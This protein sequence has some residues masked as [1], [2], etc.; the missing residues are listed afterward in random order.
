MLEGKGK[1][2]KETDICQPLALRSRFSDT[3]IPFLPLISSPRLTRSSVL[4]KFADGQR[5]PPRSALAWPRIRDSCLL[6]ESLR[7]GGV[8]ERRYYFVRTSSAATARLR[9][10]YVSGSLGMYLRQ[11]FLH[12]LN[13][14]RFCLFL[15]S[16]IHYSCL[17]YTYIYVCSVCKYLKSS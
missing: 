9:T 3:I 15:L 7:K 12:S 2:E 6:T 13:F 17:R 16:F 10:V 8:I 5:T 11:N 14:S 1:R 4:L